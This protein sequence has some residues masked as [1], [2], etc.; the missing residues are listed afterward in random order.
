M[1]RRSRWPV[2][3]LACVVLSLAA[4]APAQAGRAG[5]TP[6]HAARMG[7]GDLAGSVDLRHGAAFRCTLHAGGPVRRVVLAGNSADGSPA[8]LR[9]AGGPR[10]QVF[11]LDDGNTPPP[12]GSRFFRALDLNRDGWTDLMVLASS[13][14]NGQEW[15]EVFRYVPVSGRFVR[16]DVLSAAGNIEPAAGRRPCVEMV[17]NFV[18]KLTNAEYC[19]RG[20][21]WR[22]VRDERF[23]DASTPGVRLRTRR[24]LRGGRMRVTAV[25]TLRRGSR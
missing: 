19:W 5:C 16:D 10:P 12:A 14:A 18:F 11:R 17:T 24:E 22:L 23:E 13:G 1:I 9:V 20:G 3:A 2:A 6:T 7:T 15:Y 21:R 4:P 8:E 25:D